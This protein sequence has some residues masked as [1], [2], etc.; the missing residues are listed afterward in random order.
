MR[1]LVITMKIGESAVG[2]IFENLI[3]GLSKLNEID[4]LTSD[5]NSSINLPSVSDIIF[6][7]KIS[8]HPRITK[9]LISLFGVDP[10]DCYWGWKAK[11]LMEAKGKKHY[12]IILSFFCNH[13]YASIIAGKYISE[14]YKTKYAVHTL[15][16]VPNPLGWS[17]NNSHYRNIMKLMSKYLQNVDALFSTN[18][19]MLNYQLKT[20]TAKKG[21]IKDVIYNPGQGVKVFPVPEF[22]IDSFIFTGGIYGVR[23]SIYLLK[24]FEKLLE[25]NPNSKLIFVG[26]K[27]LPDSFGFLK[28]LTKDKIKIVPFTRALDSYYECATALIDIDADIENDVFLSSKITTYMMINRIIICE[29]GLN[30]PARHLFKNKGSIML[31]NHDSDQLFNAMR[32]S[33]ILKKSVSFEDRK[34]TIK[35][36]QMDRII[37]HLNNSLMQLLSY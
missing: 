4:V 17:K 35:L 37:G 8:V 34:E 18:E 3:S 6:S 28:S 29:T 21:L 13:Y 19:Q 5:D 16:A 10:F 31:C 25:T 20:F 2:I 7:K 22:E 32:K 27:L 33:I 36:F 26:T 23:K 9:L 24:A 11:K 30:S 15:D 1:I 12:D 14:N